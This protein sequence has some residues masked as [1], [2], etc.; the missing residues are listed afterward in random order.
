M[1][2]RA[3]S[4]DNGVRHAPERRHPCKPLQGA[5]GTSAVLGGCTSIP[6]IPSLEGSDAHFSG[7]FHVKIG[8]RAS[9]LCG[10]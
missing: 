9:I 10:R 7:G 1:L 8:E 5:I 4:K 2:E 6:H 3:I